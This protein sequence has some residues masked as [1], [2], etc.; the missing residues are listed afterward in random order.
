MDESP[1]AATPAGMAPIHRPSFL[2]SSLLTYGSQIAAAA[3]SLVNVLVVAR[4]LG[5]VGRGDVAFLT[6]MGFL[7]S[8]IASLGVDQANVNFAGRDSRLT[9]A[10]AGNSVILSLLLGACGAGA[11]AFLVALVPA[12]GGGASGGQRW[13]ILGALPMLILNV[14][15]THLVIAFYGFRVVS[16]SVLIPPTINVVA[17]ATMAL[18]DVIS[19]TSAVSVWVAGQL[20]STGLLVWFV[21]ARLGGFGRPDRRLG[22]RAVGFGLKAHGG[23]VMLLGNYRLDQWILGAVSGSRE[24]GLYSVAVAWSEGLFFLPNAMAS[25]QRPDLVRA[26]RRDAAEQAARILRVT[27]LLTAILAALLLA[28]APFLCTTIFGSEFEGSVDDLRL[29]VAGGFGIAA[30][31][32]LGSALTAQGKPLLET[33]AIGV[34]F[35]MIVVLDVVLIP[36][37]GGEGAA[38]AAS[39]AYCAGGVAVALIFARALGARARDLVPRPRDVSWFVRTLRSRLR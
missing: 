19:V 29:L 18:T 37:Y 22:R 23:R 27:F 26:E 21:S 9:R 34:A 8:Q 12:A 39:V 33:A 3:L 20:L 31:K 25:A 36:A 11:V 1:A 5:P 2:F 7:T 32:M 16:A 28:A 14:Y 24:L 38:V 4:S 30:L 17:N 10:L 35:V 6:T 15:L 13:L